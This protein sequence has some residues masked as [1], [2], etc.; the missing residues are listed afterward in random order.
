LKKVLS[1]LRLW[2]SLIA[3]IETISHMSREYLNL[4]LSGEITPQGKL[5]D[6]LSIS[7]SYNEGRSVKACRKIKAYIGVEDEY[8][9]ITLIQL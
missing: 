8:T 5:P 2:Y 7:K 3:R 1:C 4:R 9:Y 6:M